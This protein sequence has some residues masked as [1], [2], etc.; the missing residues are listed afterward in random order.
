MVT[1]TPKAGRVEVNIHL[2]LANGSI[3]A[4]TSENHLERYLK[5]CIY[6]L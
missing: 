1:L 2:F 6:V 3:Y 4:I 5:S